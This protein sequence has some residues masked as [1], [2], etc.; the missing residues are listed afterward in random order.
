[1]SILTQRTDRDDSKSDIFLLIFVHIRCVFLCVC[2]FVGV[3]F[4]MHASCVICVKEKG[5]LCSGEVFDF[6]L[7][8]CVCLVKIEK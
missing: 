4:C 5:D 1:M 7:R 8:V 6:S 2:M 3:H